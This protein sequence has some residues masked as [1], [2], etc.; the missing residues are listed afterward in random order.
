MIRTGFY[1]DN[2]HLKVKA[3]RDAAHRVSLLKEAL[4][5]HTGAAIIYVTLQKTAEEIAALLS[6]TGQ[7]AEAYH[8]GLDAELRSEIQNRFMTGKTEIVVATIAFGMGIDK[9]DI[10]KVIHFDLPKSMEGYSQEI[11]RAGR[12]GN[13]SE[14]ILLASKD[15]VPTLENFV[16]GDTP[17][18]SGIE[19]LVNRIRTSE[20]PVFEVRP[21]ELSR[22]LDIRPLPL[23]T[24]LVYLELHGI[25]K[26]RLTFFETY[27]LK[28]EMAARDILAQFA[29][30]RRTFL[31]TVFAHTVHKR[32]WSYPD[33]EAICL[34][35]RCD[36]GRIV[37][38]LNYFEEQGWVT[39]KPGRA[40]DVYDILVT[41]FPER[42]VVD[43][44]YNLFATKETVE[45][46][47]ISEILQY[48]ESDTCLAKTL[49]AHFGKPSL[50]PAAAVPSVWASASLF[51]NP[52][53]R[54]PFP[55]SIL[56]GKPVPSFPIWRPPP[57]AFSRAFS[58]GFRVRASRNPAGF[59]DLRNSR[60]GPSRRWKNGSQPTLSEP[61]GLDS[62]PWSP[63]TVC[64][65]Q[66]GVFGPAS[67][68][69]KGTTGFDSLSGSGRKVRSEVRRPHGVRE[70][71][72][73][74]NLPGALL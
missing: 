67:F 45:V 47:R 71:S 58:A 7:I 54:P 11:G 12:D 20:V 35:S 50:L 72:L 65:N 55:P 53:G 59:R 42:E 18:K 74:A 29:G 19:K 40:V 48:A 39:L 64:R 3:A 52:S 33:M 46:A 26:P 15:G 25:L 28:F 10:R 68:T 61:C 70:T 57:P 51:R 62:R 16:Y 60:P 22:S 73:D 66:A 21:T 17:E 43:S 1:R 8:A 27:A 4:S 34:Q 5:G 23:K 30:E 13:R 32:T 41:E 63:G 31:E 37:A 14:C 38:A 44:L 9:A 2:L 6:E 49:S 36:R 24:L 69:M 56:P